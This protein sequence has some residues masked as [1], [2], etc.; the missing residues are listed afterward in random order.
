MN[1][2]TTSSAL[3]V[4]GATASSV[5]ATDVVPNTDTK[6]PIR[7]GFW[8][9][10]V[11]FGLFMA[12]A[13]WAPLDEG[14]SAP[15]TVTVAT[16]RHTIQHVQ[17]GVIQK[18]FVKEGDEVKPGDVL[19]TLDDATPRAINEAIQQ[20]YLAQRALESRLMSEASHSSSIVFHP[21]LLNSTGPFAAQHMAV[22][23][24]LFNA[25][26]AG[27][28]A[29]LAASEQAIAGLESQISGSR[30][31]LESRRAQLALHA[32]QTASVQ[33]LAEEG[34]APRNQALQ[35]EQAQGD[36]RNSMTEM[37]TT[38]QRAQASI[39]ETRQRMA[40]RQQDFAKE[41]SVQLADVRREV[42]ANQER[43]AAAAGDLGRTQ[44]K[45]PVAGQ[46]IGL[47]LSGTGGIV[48][49]GQ[50]L[51]DILPR[52]QT[53]L[54]DVR[55][56]PHVIDRVKQGDVVEVRFSSFAN[57]PQLVA[58]G[59]VAS[60]AGDAITE[61]TP[62]GTQSFYIARVA[63]TPAGLKALGNRTVQPGMTAEVLIKTGERSLLTYILHPLTKRMA[64]S[65][66]EE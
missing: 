39:L 49:P 15:A 3:Q 65:M 18:V 40:Q 50:R 58:D 60:L 8:V 27:L 37:E 1:S 57:S 11:G 2:T 32:K 30:R 43:L 31:L 34:F 10:V 38:I 47:T 19:L 7:M 36:L 61:T 55:V 62:T 46:V 21:D 35:L 6:G 14:V 54:L 5:D 51:L 9:L 12:W 53:L 66:T 16:R 52:G 23:Q 45:A 48:S 22:Q 24:Q 41:T 56:P 59:Q 29:E 42:Q 33:A 13:A 17:G 44:I 64:S 28:A 26:R 25:R 20:N 4:A 63:L